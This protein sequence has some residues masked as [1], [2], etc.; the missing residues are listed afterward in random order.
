MKIPKI[1]HNRPKFR[2]IWVAHLKYKLADQIQ[3]S[4]QKFR[5]DL[6]RVLLAHYRYLKPLR[7]PRSGFSLWVYLP[8]ALEALTENITTCTYCKENER[9]DFKT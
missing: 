6:Y 1:C 7:L 8:K 9:K 5:F 3:I 2:H 4:L